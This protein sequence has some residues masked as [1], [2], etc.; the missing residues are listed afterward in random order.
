MF[1]LLG[2]HFVSIQISM[3]QKYVSQMKEEIFPAIVWILFF[4]RMIYIQAICHR[5]YATR[6]D[7]FLFQVRNCVRSPSVEWYQCDEEENHFY[8]WISRTAFGLFRMTVKS[9]GKVYCIGQQRIY[10]FTEENIVKMDSSVEVYLVCILFTEIRFIIYLKLDIYISIH[11][12]AYILIWSPN[13][14]YTMIP[15]ELKSPKMSKNNLFP[16]PLMNFHHKA[17]KNRYKY[18]WII[19]FMRLPLKRFNQ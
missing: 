12:L 11:L 5:T 7:I 2:R 15:F 4:S 13:R 3:D 17:T 19:D 10:K 14:I 6:Y 1:S 9:K 18:R 8:E 16:T